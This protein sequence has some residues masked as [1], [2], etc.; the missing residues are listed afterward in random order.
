MMAFLPLLRFLKS[1]I[2][3]AKLNQPVREPTN[4]SSTRTPDKFRRGSLMVFYK[5]DAS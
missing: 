5:S 2:A 1:P 3:K 4:S